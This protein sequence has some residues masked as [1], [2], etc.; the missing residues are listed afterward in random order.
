MKRLLTINALAATIAIGS[1][2]VFADQGAG[3]TVTPGIGYYTF[4]NDRE[5]DNHVFGSIGLG[6][7]FANPWSIEFLYLR[8]DTE[9]EL[10]SEA[11]VLMEQF[12]LDGLYHFPR[13]ENWQTYLAAGLGDNQ[14]SDSFDAEETI[15]NAGGGLKYFFRD[16][17]AL[18]SDLRLIHSLDEEDLDVALT[19]GL[20]ILLGGTTTAAAKPAPM[21]EKKMIEDNDQDGVPDDRDNCLQTPTGAPVDNL[22]CALDSD[23]D[24]VIDLR[25]QCPDS[26]AGARVDETG[27]YIKLLEDREV[28]LNVQFANNSDVVTPQFYSEVERVAS[29]MREYPGTSVVVQ[30]HTDD[31]GSAAYNQQLSERRARAVAAVLVE[32]FNVDSSRVSAIGYGEERPLVDN[33]TAE[34][35][36]KNRRVV[37]VV[38]AQVETIAQ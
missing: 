3:F 8:G 12:R 6:Y 15:L 35:R 9:A 23:N 10:T 30:G 18:R 16:N 32:Q 27:C 20:N 4:D 1:F 37:A 14:Y 29:F 28:R 31:R 34:N 26:A 24:G 7:Q 25:D 11:D 5:L 22:G 21:P 38:K 17:V 36:A 33:D 19:L 13:Q 2:P